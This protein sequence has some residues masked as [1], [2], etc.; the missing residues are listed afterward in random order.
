MLKVNFSRFE[1]ATSTVCPQEANATTRFPRAKLAFGERL[2]NI[3]VTRLNIEKSFLAAFGAW[4]R[5][6]MKE[7]GDRKMARSR[8]NAQMSRDIDLKY[9]MERIQLEGGES[10]EKERDRI[11]ENP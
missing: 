6:K 7:D 2:R 1:G 8:R 9:E 11:L 4:T 3:S 10:R 5:M